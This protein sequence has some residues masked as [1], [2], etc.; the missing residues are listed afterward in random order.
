MIKIAS[1]NGYD[2]FE[3][4]KGDS[5]HIRDMFSSSYTGVDSETTTSNDQEPWV[6]TFIPDWFKYV[7][8][9]G[10]K[11]IES[12]KEEDYLSRYPYEDEI[13]SE[14][15][16]R[17][18]HPLFV[19]STQ[20]DVEYK[21]IFFATPPVGTEAVCITDNGEYWRGD[22]DGGYFS[23]IIGDRRLANSILDEIYSYIARVES[24]SEGTGQES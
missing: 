11:V 5:E 24:S 15:K 7:F 22:S 4:T 12:G 14:D 6:A 13:S 10:L 23:D 2:I 1:V 21:N 19:I 3:V 16:A 8:E 9:P 17:L 18:R 20:K